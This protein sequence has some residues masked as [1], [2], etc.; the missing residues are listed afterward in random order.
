MTKIIAIALQKGGVG[1]TTT[2]QHLGHALGMLGRNVLIIDLDP[3]G[4]LTNRYD[5][6]ALRGSMSD[7]LGRG[8]REVGS[9]KLQ[10]IVIPTHAP[11]VFLAPAGH[12]LADT[13]KYLDSIE[14]G[15]YLLDILLRD[16]RL[17]FDYVLIDT[18]PGRSALLVAA[19]VAADEL[20]VPVELSP[21]GFEGFSQIEETV[22]HARRLQRVRGSM[23]LEYRA[24][25][26][27]F[28]ERGQQISDAFLGALQ[29]SEHP[30]Y[31]DVMLPVSE[32]V[33]ET[34]AFEKASAP[35]PVQ[36]NGDVITRALT[37]WE[38]PRDDV[39]VRAG[40]AYIKLA[41]MVEAYV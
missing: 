36:S 24:V 20:V 19:L 34:T 37:I 38:M 9:G 5:Q 17:P 7:V 6:Q 4:S 22:Q 31:E 8:R 40:D 11:N 33:A 30:D 3:Q 25:V 27:T 39:A 35:R 2:T 14:D 18:P 32:P 16:T 23:R 21:M 12:D 28:F 15:A 1:K 10:S 41:E 13:D 26:P 29:D